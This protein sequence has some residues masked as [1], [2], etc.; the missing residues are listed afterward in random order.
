LIAAKVF[1]K[2]ISLLSLAKDIPEESIV[3]R[4][5][6]LTTTNAP[7]L[8]VPNYLLELNYQPLFWYLEDQ[9]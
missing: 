2:K 8:K 4:R 7:V 1:F 9:V 6:S 5:I 3:N